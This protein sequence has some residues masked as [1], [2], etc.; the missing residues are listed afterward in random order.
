MKNEDLK[1]DK[2]ILIIDLETTGFIQKGG[3]I[4]EIGIVSLDLEN[5]EKEILF[6]SLCRHEEM[7]L[8]EIETSWI[9]KNSDMN[10]EE[11]WNAPFIED[12]REEVQGIISS[13]TNGA[14]AYNN[15]FDFGFMEKNGFSFPRKLKCPMI[16]S[17]DICQ[18]P[19][20]NG[21]RGNK[22]PSVQE[23]WNFF[24]GTDTGYV[25]THRGADDA[26]HE[27]DIVYE[28]YLR[29]IFK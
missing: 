5:G 6:D 17:T 11:V 1:I 13:F 8:K 20:K 12:I 24:F 28:L 23:A 22:W 10:A 9:C 3:K 25:E 26:F 15:A 18:V 29:G 7:T 16:L 21:R 4:V 19:H 2:K 27:A 14:T